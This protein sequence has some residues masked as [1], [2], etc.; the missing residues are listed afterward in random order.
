MKMTFSI[1]VCTFSL[2]LLIKT[3]AF[4]QLKKSNNTVVWKDTVGVLDPRGYKQ[5]TI[6]YVANGE[7]YHAVFKGISDKATKE[8]KFKMR[9]N[10]ANPQ[11]VQI[12]FW[13]PVFIEGEKTH[14]LVARVKKIQTPDFF[15][16]YAAII[17]TYS[18]PFPDKIHKFK[19]W[20]Y[21][22]QDFRQRYPNLR[23]GQLYEVEVLDKNVYRSVL[24]LDKPIKDT[25]DAQ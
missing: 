12:E 7:I 21:L 23:E 24:H 20:V 8:Q 1:S 25:A 2:V 10:I 16:R 14:K 18:I 6:Y 11:E 5:G 3:T 4:P 13:N 17:Y 22:P 15:T 19:R 9:Y